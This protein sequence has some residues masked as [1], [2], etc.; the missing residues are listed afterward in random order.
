MGKAKKK[1]GGG[2]G[3]PKGIP[4]DDDEDW[5]S[6]LAAEQNVANGTSSGD[7]ALSSA[8][9]DAPK[10]DKTD[11]GQENETAV[12]P[13]APLDAAAAFLAAQGISVGGG[14]A[15]DNKKKK[16]KKP[17]EKKPEEKKPEKVRN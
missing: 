3:G 12:A 7:G 10:V 11:A 2:A 15:A 9:S 5:D 17:A 6:I 8:A 14:A 4:L 1:T 16:K 13:P